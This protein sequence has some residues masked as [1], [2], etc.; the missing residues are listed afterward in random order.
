MRQW[1]QKGNRRFRSP[2][3]VRSRPSSSAEAEAAPA[4]EP[5]VPEAVAVEGVPALSA[6]REPGSHP[7]RPVPRHCLAEGPI[8]LRPK[9]A[10]GAHRQAMAAD[11][12]IADGFDVGGAGRA[13]ACRGHLAVSFGSGGVKVE[14]DLPSA[15]SQDIHLRIARC[16]ADRGDKMSRMTRLRPWDLTGENQPGTEF[17]SGK[18]MKTIL[19]SVVIPTYNSRAYIEETISGVLQQTHSNLQVVVVD[20]G[21]TDG[22][23]QL[24]SNLTVDPRVSLNEISHRGVS[25]ARNAGLAMADGDFIAFLDHDDCW[26]PTKLERQL[27]ILTNT[28]A[29]CVVGCL[30]D[31]ISHSGKRFGR[32]GQVVRSKDQELIAQAKIMP[33]PMSSILFRKLAIRSVGGFNEALATASTGGVDDL[34]LL[35]RLAS[36]CRIMCVPETLGAYRHHRSSFTASHFALQRAGTRFVQEHRRAEQEGRQLTWGEFEKAY[37]RTFRMLREDRAAEAYYTAGL[38]AIEGEWPQAARAALKSVFLAPSYTFQR[39]RVN[40]PWARHHQ[41]Q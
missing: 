17:S 35:S 13:V 31:L 1:G 15:E 23:P 27:T 6:L 32:T 40:R 39:L 7:S 11:A 41:G 30:M 8:D 37:R 34:D 20:D 16:L 25:G 14:H 5:R 21:S 3:L 33:F 9:L 19:V 10:Y 4:S 24:V 28:P 29:V 26:Y 38:R 18:S 2:P 22:T 12:P 36:V